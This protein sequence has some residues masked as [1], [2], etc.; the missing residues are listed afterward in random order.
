MNDV[1]N[2]I[3]LKLIRSYFN[4]IRKITLSNIINIIMLLIRN[5]ISIFDRNLMVIFL[6]YILRKLKK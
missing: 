2:Q 3:V 1:S 4:R 5:K 6:I